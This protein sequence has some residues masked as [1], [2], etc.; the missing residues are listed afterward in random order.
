MIE[1]TEMP[2]PMSPVESMP[3]T[4][5]VTAEACRYCCCDVGN[6]IT[7]TA[8]LAQKLWRLNQSPQ[9]QFRLHASYFL[10]HSFFN[11]LG[12]LLAQ[13]HRRVLIAAVPRQSLSWVQTRSVKRQVRDPLGAVLAAATES[14]QSAT[15]S[16]P[17]QKKL[18]RPRRDEEITARFITL[19]DESGTVHRDVR[20]KDA[21]S[22]LNRQDHF[23]IE[24]DPLAE[25]HPVCR[26]T[27]KKA[28]FEKRQ[29]TSR[30][31]AVLKEVTFGWNVSPHDMGHKLQKAEQFLAKGNKVRIEVVAK[32]GQQRL[33]RN[34]Q[35]EVIEKIVA[36]LKPYAKAMKNPTFV[37]NA[38]CIIVFEGKAAE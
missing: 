29:N 25:P 4:A 35:E 33:P 14:P 13:S 19:V 24:V 22:K 11:M 17:K 31:E 3:T 9:W 1:R 8:L 26:I 18:G 6:G 7:S 27:P 21:I 2:Y 36:Q 32:K 5:V 12:R 20:I 37:Q 28:V 10:T 34:A 16:P 23:L 38:T 30:P 15:P